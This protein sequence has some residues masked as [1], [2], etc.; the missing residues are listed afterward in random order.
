V[1]ATAPISSAAEVEHAFSAAAVL[2]WCLVGRS[3]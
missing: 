2:A 3:W 1:Y